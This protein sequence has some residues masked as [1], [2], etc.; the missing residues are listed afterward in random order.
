MSEQ[1]K[2][3]STDLGVLKVEVRDSAHGRSVSPGEALVDSVNSIRDVRVRLVEEV[4]PGGVGEGSVGT[5]LKAD[6][7]WT[8]TSAC[9][10]C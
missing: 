2:N 1:G 6:L 4:R 5:R 10:Q 9:E 3:E 7:A 8:L